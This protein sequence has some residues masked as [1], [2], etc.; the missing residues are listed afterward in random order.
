MRRYPGR[1]R[2]KKAMKVRKLAELSLPLLYSIFIFSLSATPGKDIPAAVMGYST[3]LHFVLYF[4]YGLTLFALFK[5]PYRTYLAGVLFAASDEIHQYFVPGR[6]CDPLDF[7]TD[8]VALATVIVI[9]ILW[10]PLFTFLTSSPRE[11]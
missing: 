2:M 10:K 5:E 9:I 7:L 6:S 1:L 4:F 11:L 3:L 8:A